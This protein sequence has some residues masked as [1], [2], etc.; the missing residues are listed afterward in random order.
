MDGIIKRTIFG[1]IVDKAKAE[2]TNSE[3][4][5]KYINYFLEG[6]RS[7]AYRMSRATNRMLITD[8]AYAILPTF[9]SPFRKKIKD[10][11]SNNA[12]VAFSSAKSM[13]DNVNRFLQ[14]NYLPEEEIH[15]KDQRINESEKDFTSAVGDEFNLKKIVQLRESGSLD[16]CL[17]DL[18][19]LND[20]TQSVV[21][22]IRNATEHGHSHAIVESVPIKG[23]PE[24]GEGFKL[25]NLL[26]KAL[27]SHSI[28]G[29][30]F[31]VSGESMYRT[32]RIIE[33]SLRQAS[34]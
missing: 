33:G 28:S 23:I 31:L 10:S 17:E 14:A 3:T 30:A 26:S 12:A 6:A 20:M 2:P 1:Q 32:H 21:A 7:E 34:I 25:T 18:N 8:I 11:I 29:L 15:R 4:R 22:P 9:L 19:C 13:Y 24:C 27:P 5:S 16:Y